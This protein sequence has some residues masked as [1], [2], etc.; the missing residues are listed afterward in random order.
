VS[1][2]RVL[3]IVLAGGEGKRLY[4]L[5]ADRAK[6]AVPFAGHYRLI[7]FALS[8]LAN[9][10]YLRMVVL[11]QYK[12][13]SLGLHLSR[14]WRLSTLLDMYVTMVPAQMRH[15]P[16][17]FSGSADAIFQNLNLVND[18]R[19]DYICV[20]GA[21]HI[22]RMDPR[23][24]VEAHIASGAGVTVQLAGT[25]GLH[26]RR[27]RATAIGQETAFFVER[28]AL[29]GP[30]RVVKRAID[31]V[32]ASVGLLVASPLLLGA[33]VAIRLHDR[34][35]VLFRQRRVGRH[36][37][38]FRM[39]KL[40]T[41][42]V[43]AEDMMPAIQH[44]NRRSGPMFKHEADPRVTRPGRPLRAA[45]VDELPQLWNV[46]RGQMSLVGPRPALPSEAA[47]F[48]ENLNRRHTVRPGITG[49][50]QVEARDSERFEDLERHDLFYV[51]N[52]SVLL[53][54]ALLGRT[55]GGVARRA[56]RISRHQPGALL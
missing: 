16:Y 35:P 23:Q 37:E 20:F 39:L 51:E 30:Q 53:D 34:G 13:H 5:T 54:L 22:Y 14:T 15:G 11:T 6:P 50:W 40:R 45:S 47:L 49:L 17:W 26:H 52:W 43:D 27:L 32:G 25:L 8:N 42:D 2:P 21:D 4:P 31:L 46:L 3:S 19:P 33:A 1:E 41:M 44:E 7:D 12:S 55:V 9:A 48:G 29:T 10:G 56:W 36:G 38:M 28:V 24:M 18:D